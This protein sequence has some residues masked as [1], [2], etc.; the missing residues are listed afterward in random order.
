MCLV[1][2]VILIGVRSFSVQCKQIRLDWEASDSIFNNREVWNDVIYLDLKLL[3][4]NILITSF[5]F[6]N[7]RLTSL[8]YI[9]DIS[10]M[11][12]QKP[13]SHWEDLMD[14]DF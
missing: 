11:L 1:K 9:P 10:E 14:W 5:I 3:F 6:I 8:N 4:P 7:I 12:A 2:L 13:I